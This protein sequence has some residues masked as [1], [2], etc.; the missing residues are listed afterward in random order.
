MDYKEIKLGDVVVRLG[1]LGLDFYVK[2]KKVC[3]LNE[4]GAKAL[5]D[6]LQEPFKKA[7]KN[8]KVDF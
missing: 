3:W 4:M 1:K 8:E 5:R 6:F 2:N 7:G